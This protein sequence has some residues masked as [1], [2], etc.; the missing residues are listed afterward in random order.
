MVT[1][2]IRANRSIP[3]A[4]NS[5][6]CPSPLGAVTMTVERLQ[7][8]DDQLQ[9]RENVLKQLKE[10]TGVDDVQI[11]KQALEASRNEAGT[12]DVAQAANFLVDENAV[13]YN[14]NPTK[15]QQRVEQ[16][17]MP[18]QTNSVATNTAGK[19]QEDGKIF[20]DTKVIDLTSENSEKD[21]LQKAIALSLQDQHH[22]MLGGQVTAEEQDISMVLEQSLAESKIGTKR[23]RGEIW[24]DPVNPHERKRQGFWPV[25]L[26]NVGNTC[27]FSAVIQSLFHLPIFRHLVLNFVC[28]PE[29]WDAEIV[30]KDENRRNLK[31]MEELRNLFALMVG[32]QR[33]YVDPSRAVEIF[34]EAFQSGNSDSQQDVSEFTHK[35]LEWLED[36]FKSSSQSLSEAESTKSSNPMLD[37]FYGQFRAEGSNDGRLFNNV[38]KFGQYPLQV[39]GFTNIHESLEAA[40]AQ[41]I[42]SNNMEAMTKSGQEHWFTQLP[43]VLLFELSRFQ[44]NQQLGRP[45]KIHNRFEFP[46][47]IYMDRYM[48]DNKNDVKLKRDE[49]KSLKQER[50]ELQYQLDKFLNFGSGSKR[51]PLI[52]VLKYTLE[53]AEN[54]N[55]SSTNDVEM[56]SAL[57]SN[58]AASASGVFKSTD[59]VKTSPVTFNKSSI[60]GFLGPSHVTETELRVLQ[61]C[62][63]RWRTEAENNVKDL[64]DK[65]KTKDDT[66][67]NMYSS[68][69][70]MRVPY[71]L[72]AVLVH[73]GQAASGHYWA[74]VYDHSK[75]HWLKFNDVTV[76]NTTWEELQKESF[77]GYHNASAYCLMYIDNNR[78]SLVNNGIGDTGQNSCNDMVFAKDIKDLID[79]D[80]E[81]FRIEIARWDRDQRQMQMKEALENCPKS[82]LAD[83]PLI[84]EREKHRH[85]EERSEALT[86]TSVN[87]LEDNRVE[88]SASQYVTAL[89][90][91][92]SETTVFEPTSL[93]HQLSIQAVAKADNTLKTKG[94]D[95]ALKEVLQSELIRYQTLSSNQDVLSDARLQ[96]IAIYLLANDVPVDPLINWTILDQFSNS[97]LDADPRGRRIRQGAEQ[98]L[99][100]HLRKMPPI[101]RKW[102]KQWQDDFRDFRKLAALFIT[103]LEEFHG[104]RFLEALPYLISAC[105]L[106]ELIINSG[107]GKRRG[108]DIRLLTYYRRHCLLRVNEQAS[109]QF[110]SSD[111]EEAKE[112]IQIMSDFVVPCMN[113][114][115]SS[116]SADDNTAAEEIRST[117]CSKLAEEN[118]K[119]ELLA[120]F[121]RKLLD[122]SSDLKIRE[123]APLFRSTQDLAERFSAAM[124]LSRSS[125]FLDAA[126]QHR[127]KK[128][129]KMVFILY[130][131]RKTRYYE[132]YTH[133]DVT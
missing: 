19:T 57:S 105:T 71:R 84:L 81:K 133:T 10:V 117:W 35:L 52:D 63:R 26:K 11:L 129:M 32:T 110:E 83:G 5:N 89:T 14:Q 73:E 65:I 76:T 101:H 43:P 119:K 40:T 33:K 51:F 98:N 61:S 15:G 54:K 16:R 24:Q 2:E 127:K 45:E 91:T 56:S 12:Y 27:W 28:P 46:E 67:R 108:L 1:Q 47:V 97:S 20:S 88:R 99:M 128:S 86:K 6:S 17:P 23:K 9:S 104:Q 7:T 22:G 58:N 69:T 112:A 30:E 130:D 106:N 74:Y 18:P 39:N 49:I 37:L 72:H 31:F 29:D 132:N 122:P 8:G 4:V 118:D 123:S 50:E 55:K 116:S 93:Q 70:L 114:L 38:E 77:G 42:E 41:E 85:N 34:K 115:C 3:V 60:G 96:H 95:E 100:K 79:D 59:D 87:T 82:D 62:L 113:L 64:Q 102:Y 111:T 44:F 125:G 120:D 78:E 36:A 94:V 126:L 68:E 121:L 92:A 103:G 75:K 107:T 48:E 13:R 53:F 124:N 66:I 131:H 80:N 90:D 21:E 25:G 109:Q